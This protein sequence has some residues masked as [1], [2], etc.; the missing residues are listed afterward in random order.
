MLT[1]DVKLFLGNRLLR[2][3]LIKLKNRKIKRA[4]CIFIGCIDSPCGARCLDQS[5]TCHV[6]SVIII[7][8]FTSDL[9]EIRLEL[10]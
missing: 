5:A 10:D 6:I 1:R 2:Y 9:R 3:Y 4:L 7:S 8:Q